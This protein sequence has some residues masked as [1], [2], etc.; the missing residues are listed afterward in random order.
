MALDSH[1]TSGLADVDTEKRLANQRKHIDKLLL[2]RRFSEAWLFCDAVDEDEMWRKLGE[3]AIADLNVE[4]GMFYMQVWIKV[5]WV[6]FYCT[7]KKEG[8]F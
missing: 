5:P 8:V 1:N 4:F 3:A 2:L 6:K 7:T